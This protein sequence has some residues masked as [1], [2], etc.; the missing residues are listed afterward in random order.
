MLYVGNVA[1]FKFNAIAARAV[2]VIEYGGAHTDFCA[3]LN[4]LADFKINER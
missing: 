1:V 3:E 4:C 2:R